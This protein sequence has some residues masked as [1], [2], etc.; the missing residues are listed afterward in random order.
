MPNAMG[1]RVSF[2]NKFGGGLRDKNSV[3]F[4]LVEPCKGKIFLGGD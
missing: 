1:K 4:I 3:I 2:F